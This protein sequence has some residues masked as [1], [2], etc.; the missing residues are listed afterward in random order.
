MIDL[1]QENSAKEG[2]SLKECGLKDDVPVLSAI[3]I[4]SREGVLRQLL[5]SVTQPQRLHLLHYDE[6]KNTEIY[7]ASPCVFIVTESMIYKYPVGYFHRILE[8][9]EK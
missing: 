9:C 3:S 4:D 6:D 7:F 5:S 8:R 2:V 1:A